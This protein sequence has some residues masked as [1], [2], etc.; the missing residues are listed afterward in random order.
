MLRREKKKEKAVSKKVNPP[1]IGDHRRRRQCYLWV[2]TIGTGL[3]K[4]RSLCLV[5]FVTAAAYNFCLALPAA[6]TQPEK[7]LLALCNF[8]K[9]LGRGRRVPK[10]ATMGGDGEIV[11]L[12]GCLSFATYS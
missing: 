6:L 3:G 9:E 2:H 5:N 11:F 7:H 10:T 12:C 4:R 1:W 8:G